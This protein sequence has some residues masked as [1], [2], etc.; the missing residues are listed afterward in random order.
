MSF[1][2]C[3]LFPSLTPRLVDPL[4]HRVDAAKNEDAE[5][6]KLEKEQMNNV[7][8]VKEKDY[9]LT[10]IGN[11][12]YFLLRI[13]VLNK[14]I[15]PQLYIVFYSPCLSLARLDQFLGRLSPLD[16]KTYVSVLP[17]TLKKIFVS[18]GQWMNVK[19]FIV[20]IRQILGWENASKHL[21]DTLGGKKEYLE[22]TMIYDSRV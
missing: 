17:M 2:M 13:I 7:K 16:E 3:P 8:A 19:L 10:P 11:F 12:L 18:K 20:W 9:H 6:E 15:G 1:S 5:L 21:G 4:W 14:F 22:T